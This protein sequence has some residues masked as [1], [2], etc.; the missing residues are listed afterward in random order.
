MNF[1]FSYT[2][3][4]GLV[5]IE[6]TVY[7][8][9][10]GYFMECFRESD[11]A[12]AGIP[13]RFVQENESMSARAVLR[14]LHFQRTEPQA[15]L[16]RVVSGALLDVAVDLREGS[17][18]YGKWHAEHLSAKNRRQMFI[19]EG[20]A[21]GFLALENDTRLNYKCSRYYAPQDEDGI[22]WNDPTLA[23][24]WQLER[25]GIELSELIISE[26]DCKWP[27]L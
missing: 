21:H 9:D 22:A 7:G 23:I 10:R 1:K 27:N 18:T 11:Y 8:D 15:K 16:V 26:K 24:D 2:P 19:P 12:E 3:I 13:T 14:G 6:P 4:E 25:W 20:F 17:A 5:V